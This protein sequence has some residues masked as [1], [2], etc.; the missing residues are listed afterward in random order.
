MGAAHSGLLAENTR[1]MYNGIMHLIL[2]FIVLSVLCAGDYDFDIPCRWT[3]TLNTDI[4]CQKQRPPFLPNLKGISIFRDPGYSETIYFTQPI[5]DVWLHIEM[6][7]SSHNIDSGTLFLVKFGCGNCTHRNY[8]HIS[9]VPLNRYNRGFLV[10]EPKEKPSPRLVQFQS[11][12]THNPS[13]FCEYHARETDFTVTRF[14]CEY[15]DLSC[16]FVSAQ[17]TY[18]NMHNMV[19]EWGIKERDGALRKSDNECRQEFNFPLCACTPIHT[20]M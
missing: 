5:E 1:I 4:S 6:D 16:F 10:V 2:F 14:L 20:L 17:V 9:A 8:G 11:V 12:N 3:R 18:A 7:C 15:Q 13:M 19:I